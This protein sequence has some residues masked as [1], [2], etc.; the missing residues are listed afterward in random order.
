MP[1]NLQ[2]KLDFTVTSRSRTFGVIKTAEGP[3][4]PEGPEG[5][6]L[7]FVHVCVHLQAVLATFGVSTLKRKWL[8]VWEETQVPQ[9]ARISFFPYIKSVNKN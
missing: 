5:C 8:M 6:Y 2:S 4:G 7:P 3:E 1:R 9:E